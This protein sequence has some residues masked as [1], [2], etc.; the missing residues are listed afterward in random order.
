M[1]EVTL[2]STE[3][4]PPT[5]VVALEKSSKV[6][7]PVSLLAGTNPNA[8]GLTLIESPQETT[9]WTTVDFDG[10]PFNFV[11]DTGASMSVVSPEPSGPF[12]EPVSD[13]FEAASAGCLV[14]GSEVASGKWNVGPIQ[15][16]PQHLGI[17]AL[18]LL[19]GLGV[20]GSDVFFE[21][22]V[23]VIDYRNARMFLGSGVGSVP[24]KST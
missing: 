9:I 11:V 7:T 13:R 16:P 23:V 15:L 19:V 4:P 14:E 1:Q 6:K 18:P 17:V 24:G 12:L 5:T 8:L 22:H 21:A 2:L 20:L 3:A 10:L